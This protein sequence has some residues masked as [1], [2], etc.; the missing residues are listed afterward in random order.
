MKHYNMSDLLRGHASKIITKVSDRYKGQPYAMHNITDETSFDELVS[1]I[2]K[3]SGEKLEIMVSHYP[4]GTSKWNIRCS[5][6][7]QK[8]SRGSH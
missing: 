8:T 7:F 5:A 1:L 4:P 3:S 2:N 6:I